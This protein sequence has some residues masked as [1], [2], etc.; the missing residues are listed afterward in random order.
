M[1][2]LCH[3]VAVCG[4]CDMSPYESQCLHC[5]NQIFN[6]FNRKWSPVG[7]WEQTASEGTSVLFSN[8]I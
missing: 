8:K 2:R 4:W 3:R 1:Q 6:V 7:I 5:V